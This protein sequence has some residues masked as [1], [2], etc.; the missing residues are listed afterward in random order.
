MKKK[1]QRIRIW[2]GGI[3]IL[4]LLLSLTA[5]TYAWFSSNRLV[6]TDRINARSGTSELKLL[7]SQYGGGN[8]RGSQEAPIA[9]VNQTLQTQLFPVST[10]DLKTFVYNPAT[11]NGMAS[12][13]RVVTG[14]ENYYHGRVYL[15]AEAQGQPATSRVALYLDQ[16]EEA[17]G[18]IVSGSDGLLLNAARL[19]L[20]F[21]DNASVIFRLSDQENGASDQVRNT[22]L[23]GQTLGDGKV[24]DGTGGRIRQANDP[25]V[26]LDTY[27]I[28][29]RGGET[30]LPD[31]PLIYLDL[32]R[33]YPLDIYFYLEGCDPD[34]SSSVS[35]SGT[36]LHLAF[37][38]ILTD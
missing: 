7:V 17:G 21:S 36:D 10:A 1:G 27:T 29:N 31:Q 6:D 12:N 34:C 2:A 28:Q 18:S 19:G 11:V 4:L 30:V 22:V 8:F 13:F 14:E 20:R 35:Y 33:E 26:S 15:K 3:T 5:A 9:Q 24:L 37:Y 23:N 38:G 25:A 32:N 16:G